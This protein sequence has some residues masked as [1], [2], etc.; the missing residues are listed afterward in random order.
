M[1]RRHGNWHLVGR[2][3]DPVPASE[4]DVNRVARTYEKRGEDLR[5]AHGALTRLSRLDGWRGDAAETFAES[6]DD[7]VKDLDKAATKYE[8]AGEALRTYALAVE[9]ARE[10]TKRALDDA[11]EADARRR[12][13]EGDPLAGVT[14]PT[15][16]QIDDAERQNRRH[17]NALT[18]LNAAEGKVNDAMSN[19][20]TAASTCAR[21]IRAA[22][23]SFK[24]HWFKD[25]FVRKNLGAFELV[26][27]ALEIAAVAIAA[28]GLVVALCFTAPAWLVAGLFVAGIAAAAILAGTRTM[29]VLSEAGDHT[30]ADVGWDVVGIG[31]AVVGGRAVFSLGRQKGALGRTFAALRTAARSSAAARMTPLPRFILRFKGGQGIAGRLIRGFD[32]FRIRGLAA[33]AIRQ[34]DEIANLKV[35]WGARLRVL[36]KDMATMRAQIAALDDLT[37]PGVNVS[38]ITQNLDGLRDALGPAI[39]WNL[40]NTGVSADSA[41]DLA[42]WSVSGAVKDEMETAH[43]RV[44]VAGR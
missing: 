1:T 35:G 31:L 3:S 43:W 10:E 19:L 33:P 6:A 8:D 17:A 4:Y 15:D 9:T 21:K 28:I 24:D 20:A 29:L 38:K 37:L 16:Q 11:E 18:A 5:E 41:G 30:W 39:R 2:D 12:A 34:I 22:S 42:G 13:N 44:T 40:I 32:E 25:D 14:E 7:R 27:K 36:D 23:D 26:I